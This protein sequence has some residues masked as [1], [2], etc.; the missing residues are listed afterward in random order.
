[1][2]D[3]ITVQGVV[4]SAM[5]IGEYDKRIVLLTRERGKISAFV[6]GAR[7]LNS[8]FMAAAEPFVF[9]SFTLYEGRSSYNLNQVN[10]THHFMELA[11]MQP[12][13]YYGYYFLEL[14]DYFGREG[15][16]EKNMMN[17][18]YL[19]VKALLN[20][21]IDDRLVRCI[22]ELRTMTEQGLMPELFRCVNCGE[23]IAGKENLFFSQEAH[24]I[25][26]GDCLK[27][28]SPGEART[29][30]RISQV[31]LYTMQYIVSSPM[32]KLYSFTVTDEVLWELERHIQPY[33]AGNTDKKFKSL[34]IL[35]V[36]M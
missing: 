17:L 3:L 23:E 8:P 22:F 13:I 15:T 26:D 18:L 11:A 4:I 19:T 31:A 36:M 33:V 21:G 9:G 1:M 24:G 28:A 30:R 20:P 5:P 6:R 7:R 16:D 32:T 29:A 10:V 25:L 14:A 2:S 27:K 35:E 34:Q 12:G